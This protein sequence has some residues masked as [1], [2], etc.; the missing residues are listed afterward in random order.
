MIREDLRVLAKAKAVWAG[1]PDVFVNLGS[2]GQAL[3]VRARLESCVVHCHE[4]T[5]SRTV[6]H[7]GVDYGTAHAVAAPVIRTTW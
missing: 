3:S 4:S 1:S 5:C 2:A 7:V 6:L